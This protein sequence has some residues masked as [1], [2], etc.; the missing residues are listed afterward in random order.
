ML[1]GDGGSKKIIDLANVHENVDVSNKFIYWL[2]YHH[3]RIKSHIINKK[4]V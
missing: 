3:F 1:R 4:M 2:K